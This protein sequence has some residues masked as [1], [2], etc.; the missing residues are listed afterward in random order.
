MLSALAFVALAAAVAPE[1]TGSLRGRVVDVRG[2]T[3]LGA[4]AISIAGTS[5]SAT[6]DDQGLFVIDGVPVGSHS[7]A[8]RCAGYSDLHLT[9]IAV[10][11]S[12]P[13]FIN[14]EMH[15][16]ISRNDQ[17][18]VTD[19]FEESER[20][21]A[22]THMLGAEELQRTA[23][24]GDLSR[25]LFAIPGVVQ[26]EDTSNDLIVRGGSPTE[27]G[28]YIDNIPVPNINHFPQEGAS[29]G[30]IS[31][32]NIGFVE[33]VQVLTGGFGAEYGNRLSSIV[34]IKYR[35]GNRAGFNGQI[36]LN[37]TGAGGELE[38][39][40]PKHKGSWMISAKRSY[41]DLLTQVVGADLD[42]RYHDVQGKV[43]YDL[44][45][46]H[47][48]TLLDIFGRSGNDRS[49]DQAVA[50][51]DSE[52]YDRFTQNTIGLDWRALWGERGYSNTSLSYAFIKG[53]GQWHQPFSPEEPWRSDYRDAAFS[54]RNVNRL[55]LSATRRLE[56]GAEASLR[57]GR[58]L[59][60]V[61]DQDV[62]LTSWDAALFASLA[63]SQKLTGSLGLRS[64]RDPYGHRLHFAPR[65]SIS[66]TP[67]G[68][69]TLSAAYGL[70]RQNLPFAL[71]RQSPANERLSELAA[72]H[73]V[74]GIA[75][76]L[77]ADTRVTLEVYDKEYRHFPLAPNVPSRF[78]IDDVTGRD[79]NFW[80]YDSLVDTGMAYSRGVELM[81]Q[82]KMSKHLYG[83]ISGS[84]FR[85]RYRDYKGVW[86]NRTH[87]NRY[88]ANVIGGY[89]PDKYWEITA[90]WVFAGGAATTPYQVWTWPGGGT[91]NLDWNNWN[92]D[93]LPNYSNLGLRLDRRVYFHKTSLAWYFAVWNVYNRKN[94]RYYYWN[95][96]DSRLDAS[97]QW[98]RFPFLGM[99]FAF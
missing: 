99:E 62:R 72:T 35:E 19:Y 92:G 97:Y 94:V 6:T 13:T 65:A 89:R 57:Q 84:L 76:R 90:R 38:G 60:A 23:P 87:D 12:R 37:M 28:Y 58:A 93:H 85:S 30:G 66:Y 33:D 40:L 9:D 83:V 31:M 41:L 17:V 8:F 64:D 16:P 4:V 79:R 59:N 44:S 63:L 71:V 14:A 69:L 54:L 55:Q 5:L 96:K 68:R 70:Y 21:R 46:R 24:G 7:V 15:L 80:T 91:A 29:G 95:W 53:R 34:D 32:L 77:A 48:L 78:V 45:P 39:P 82:R 26:S 56:F 22:V 27:N 1:P 43:V 2:Q 75:Y 36:D 42:T 81:L 67:A 11:P 20:V 73:Y 52:G 18:T 3:P 86:R 47:R 98:A 10:R 61:T 50:I 25:A 74:A 88:V 51:G 49:Q